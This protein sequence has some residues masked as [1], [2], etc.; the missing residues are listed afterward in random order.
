LL[1]G[2]APSGTD[3]LSHHT[4][5]F[6]RR[7]ALSGILDAPSGYFLRSRAIDSLILG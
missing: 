6:L 7:G 3:V 4:R 1:G 5:N 2:L